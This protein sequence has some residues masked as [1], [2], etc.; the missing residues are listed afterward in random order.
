MAEILARYIM[1][2]PNVTLWKSAVSYS[3]GVTFPAYPPQCRTK[4]N[5]NRMGRA[6]WVC[7]MH[8]SPLHLARVAEHNDFIHPGTPE[9]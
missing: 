1:F 5:W 9:A 3:Q 4:D 6:L 8:T 7:D 2:V